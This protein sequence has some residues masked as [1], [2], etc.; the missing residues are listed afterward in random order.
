MDFYIDIGFAV[1]LRLL[2]DRVHTAKYRKAFLKLRDA[3]NAVYGDE[4]ALPNRRADD[5]KFPES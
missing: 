3:I 1:L 2:K 4:Q 5:V